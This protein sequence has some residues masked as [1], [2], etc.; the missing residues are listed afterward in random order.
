[1]IHACRAAGP[2]FETAAATSRLDD[3]AL[4]DAGPARP[5]GPGR[6][7]SKRKRGVSW[8]TET[9]I[10]FPRIQSFGTIPKE[11]MYNDFDINLNQ[12]ASTNAVAAVPCRAVYIALLDLLRAD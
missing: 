7:S 5:V 12:L 1:M 2:D 8:G 10:M 4:D 9:R 11:G 6:S 3:L